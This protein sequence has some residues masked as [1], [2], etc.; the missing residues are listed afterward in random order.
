MLRSAPWE[1]AAPAWRRRLRLVLLLLAAGG[2]A[3]LAAG[4]AG[5]AGA[6]AGPGAGTGEAP[7]ALAP[8]DTVERSIGAGEVHAFRAT[9]AGAPLLLVVDQRGI[10]L[11]VADRPAAGG[12]P[13]LVD[14]QNRRWGAEVLLLETAGEHRVE[15]QSL[16]AHAAPGAYSLR[17]EANP[18]AGPDGARR[19]AAA[20]AMT[21]ASRK[22][23]G[24]TLEAL[25]R[26][27]AAY[28]E[29]LEGWRALGD[30]AMEAEALFAVAGREDWLG[31]RVAA[32]DDFE[33][34]LA[35]WRQLG[36][37]RREADTLDRLGLVRLELGQNEAAR[38][39]I[40][41]SLA[42]WRR[43]GDPLEE[44][45]TLV[46]AG[47]V[48]HSSG[49]LPAAL[50]PYRQALAVF[51]G[52][53][54]RRE[55]ARVLNNLGG[56]YDHLGEPEA[57]LASY[58][59]ALALRR[60]LGDIPGVAQT[61]GNIAILDR[62]LGDWEAALA[63]YQQALG[64]LA[65]LHQPGQKASTLNNLA[66]LYLTLG[67]P[68]RALPLFEEALA[69]HHGLG[70]R[71]TAALT[72]N[73][74]GVAWRTLGDLDRALAEH[75]QALAEAAQLD[76]PWLQALIRLQVAQVRIEQADAA[77][78]ADVAAAKALLA[79]TGDPH[80][81]ALALHLEGRVL[82][83]AGRPAAALGVLRQALELRRSIHDRAG[84]AE[85][86]DELAAVEQ[87]LGRR[88]EARAHAE[89]AI[90]AVEGLRTGV[91]S[92]SL[93][94]SFLASRHRA[95]ELLI[96]LLMDRHL[97]EPAAGFDRRALEVSE[98]ARARSLL[99]ILHDGSPGRRE[100]IPAELLARRRA[101]AYRLSA[102][103]D[104]DGPPAVG[105]AA[106]ARDA[107]ARGREVE[108]LLAE[109]DGVEAEI[110]RRAPGGGAAGDFAPLGAEAIPRLLDPGT[111]LLEIALGRERSYA[112]TI[113]E[114]GIR[115]AVLPGERE[116]GRQARQLHL[117]LSTVRPGGGPGNGDGLARVL[118][119][120][121]W[122][123]IA[124]AERLVVVP[125]A[126]LDL[127]PWSALR[128]PLP[129]HGWSAGERIPLIELREV[130]EI[131]SAT[132]LAV[133]RRRLAGRP[134]AARRAAVFADPVFAADDPR[135]AAAPRPAASTPAGAGRDGGAPPPAPAF[136]RLP[137]T[138]REAAAIAGLAP[139]GEVFAALDFA[140]SREAVLS[141][142]LRGYRVLH[143]ATH[144]V[145]D[146]RHP[147]LSGLV[148]SQVDAGGRPRRGFVRLPDLYDL[149]LAAD[150]VVLSGCR[151][152]LGKELRGEG[153]MG[154]TRGFEAAGVPRVVGSLWQVEDRASAELMT[155]FYRAMWRSGAS[156]SAALRAAQRAVR[157][158]PRYRDPHYW[159]G[160]VLQGDWRDVR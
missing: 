160:F 88:D 71:R 35:L 151:T 80:L 37:T 152:A 64:I 51:R 73:N 29:A 128:V 101:L 116:I 11:V 20:A 67:E 69:L 148:L 142:A 53:G 89:E 3:T 40:V 150:L 23:S 132:T 125:D 32:G 58:Q 145:A 106:A 70:D 140:A 82:S 16:D 26:S 85:T 59:D 134:A 133:V 62:L 1:G 43:L 131:P 50:S 33:L 135:V 44:G 113:G 79:P 109:L 114:R 147:E 137:A 153:L 103:T 63:D 21:R 47:Y 5:G 120:P 86:L 117:G 72:R 157:R 98:R 66:F 9:V 81:E 156:P 126:P 91:A 49:A 92:L 27:L 118:L 127:V 130:V 4:S 39:A 121:L 60:D 31:E 42:L 78:A 65:P 12:D 144:S 54:A 115:S 55:E 56:L 13:V 68:E 22:P 19:R 18:D 7:R 100:G 75:R 138:R 154:L 84:L 74:L 38:S 159:A 83:L 122:A 93:R 34:A 107:P 90:A 112:W 15:V 119:A 25:R 77:A 10:D 52:L 36:E 61:L 28:R 110:R 87:R 111:V 2:L 6:A 30:R 143:F 149:D 96:D 139:A 57:A 8:G 129:G 99:D 48:E 158:D 104:G 45:A 46:D 124:G 136:E 123:E 95:Y 94:A 97:A 108:S 76:D 146:T 14:A 141:G 102:R 24:W 155:R 105:G 17:L 41:D